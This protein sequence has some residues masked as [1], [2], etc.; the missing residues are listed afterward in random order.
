VSGTCL[1]SSAVARCQ[2]YG[3]SVHAATSIHLVYANSSSLILVEC[4][5]GSHPPASGPSWLR[6]SLQCPAP[7]D[8][9]LDL[10]L[11][12]QMSLAVEHCAHA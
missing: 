6:Q 4:T 8:T 5:L 9:D 7:P 3:L 2:A 10:F 12:G 1:H 11:H